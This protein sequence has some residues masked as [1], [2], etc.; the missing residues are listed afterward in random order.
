MDEERARDLER[1]LN[2][3]QYLLNDL[4]DRNTADQREI[5]KLMDEIEKE[6][7]KSLADEATIDKLENALAKKMQEIDQKDKIKQKNDQDIRQL[8]DMIEE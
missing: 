3:K 5:K 7:K 1:A 4:K 2:E 6:R 8:K